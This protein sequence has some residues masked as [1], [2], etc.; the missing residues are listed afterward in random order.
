MPCSFLLASL[1]IVGL[2]APAPSAECA[3]PSK[4]I[5]LFNGKDLTG[6]YTYIRDRGRGV[7]PKNVFTVRDGMIR[8]SGQEYGCITT[9]RGF[10]DYRLVAEYKWGK[11]THGGR[12][13]RARDSGI[14]L[15]SVGKDGAFGRVWMYSIE[16][17]L[18]EGGT[19]DI[20]VVGDKSKRF[21]VTCEVADEKQGKCYVYQPGG[22]RATI[23]SGR[24]NWFGRDPEWRDVKGFRG[25]CD[26]EKPVGQ[27]NRIECVAKGKTITVILNGATVNRAVDVQP[28]KG[29][30]QIQSEGAEIFFRKIELIPLPP[31]RPK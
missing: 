11:Q 5:S 29:K 14:L 12:K 30:I 26:V 9:E 21:Y 27:W 15:H 17:Q 24:I 23:H 31:E 20:L 22:K 1:L 4:A 13:D 25:E 19:G 28:R 18:I 10:K 3:D 16:C 6:W 7:D 8:I 2:A